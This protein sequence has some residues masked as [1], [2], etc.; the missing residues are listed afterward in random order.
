MWYVLHTKPRNEDFL[1]G[2]LSARG[3]ETF[4]PRIRVQPVNPRARKIKP[5]FPGYLFVQVNLEQFGLSN[6]QWLPGVAGLVSFG[7]EPASVPD[8]LVAG[9][10][11]HVEA[12]N[13]AG[14]ELP[15]CLKSGELVEIQ[16]GP[17][18]G[19]EAI[20]DTR[21]SGNKRVRV[22]LKLL[23]A[24]QKPLELPAV[25]IRRKTRRLTLGPGKAQA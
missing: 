3:I 18:V 8:G 4:Y 1:W 14:G 10:R 22:F 15:E 19:H 20:F 11:K 24:Q 9:I 12:V 23:H 21:P 16:D 17:F 5:Y 25:Q 2:E 13:A 7:G 6:L